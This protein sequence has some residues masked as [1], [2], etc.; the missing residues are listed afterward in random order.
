MFE[1]G[2]RRFPRTLR[3]SPV[4]A[5]KRRLWRASWKVRRAQ[6]PWVDDGVAVEVSVESRVVKVV[7]MVE[8][9]KEFSGCPG[10]WDL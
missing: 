10:R 7:E 2:P 5:V 4:Q 8:V 6:E 3:E 1:G 9:T